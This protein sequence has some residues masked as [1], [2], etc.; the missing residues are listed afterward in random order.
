MVVTLGLV[1]MLLA[2]P[3][4]AMFIGLGWP[5]YLRDKAWQTLGA[6]AVLVV[7]ATCPPLAILLALALWHTGEIN[8]LRDAGIFPPFVAVATMGA[9]AFVFML[10][11]SVPAW[12]HDWLRGAIVLAGLSQ[13]GVLG[14]QLWQLLRMQK[15]QSFHFWRD[16]LRGS[17]GN[18]VVTAAFLAFCLPLAP[19]WLMPAFGLGLLATNSFTALGG[20]ALGLAVLHPSLVG[21]WA[22]GVALALVSIIYWR[23][24]PIDSFTERKLIWRLC[25]E[26]WWYSPRREFWLGQGHDAFGRQSRWWAAQ[27]LVK[28][29]YSQ[30]HNDAAQVLLEYGALGALALAAWLGGLG[31]GMRLGD[32]WTAALLVALFCSLNQFTLH[33]PN[34]GLPVVVVAGVLWSRVL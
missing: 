27:N 8:A 11:V 4:W 16:S 22:P 33:L 14:F 3:L 12:Q 1:G 19:W 28:Q 9:V 32:P 13:V 24:N 18:R 7:G 34:T 10:T 23:G 6:M 29:R 5:P 26:A 31:F 30:A 25:V 15:P 20:A 17:F 2:V 21:Y